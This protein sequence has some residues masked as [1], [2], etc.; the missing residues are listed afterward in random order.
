MTCRR[1]VDARS[2]IVL[3]VH[4]LGLWCRGLIGHASR[5]TVISQEL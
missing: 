1:S 3:R 5:L 2:L 4:V